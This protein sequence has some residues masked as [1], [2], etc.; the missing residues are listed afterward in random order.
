MK[1][2]AT[3]TDLPN[4]ADRRRTD[5]V[6]Q[7]PLPRPHTGV[8]LAN[9]RQ[10]LLVRG[11][12]PHAGERWSLMVTVARA[13]FWDHRG[14]GQFDTRITFSRLR[15]LLESGDTEAIEEAF[16]PTTAVNR[17]QQMPGGRVILRLPDNVRPVRAHLSA[18][19]A[20]CIV[21]LHT[22]RGTAR[23]RIRQAMESERHD[24]LAWIE[25][26]SEW[27]RV[28]SPYGGILR[29]DPNMGATFCLNNQPVRINDNSWLT[30][31]TRPGEVLEFTP[32]PINRG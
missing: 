21:F 3:D 2:T 32:S 25:L 22:P 10:G 30:R 11:P 29:I 20:V 6:W 18:D 8:P 24:D 9:G 5:L 27:V 26:P 31:P 7:F 1:A 28:T 14:G 16:A 13:G 17:P 19:T 23:L 4:D 12:Q 15:A